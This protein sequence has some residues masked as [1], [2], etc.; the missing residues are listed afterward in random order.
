MRP[1][2]ADPHESTAVVRVALGRAITQ[3]RCPGKDEV[4]VIGLDTPLELIRCYR[5]CRAGADWSQGWRIVDWRKLEE[6]LSRQ[7]DVGCAASF[8]GEP[9]AATIISFRFLR[10]SLPQLVAPSNLELSD[11]STYPHD[12][13]N[14][15]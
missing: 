8:I 6:A 3:Q 7:G 4:H 13:D 10:R 14:W 2:E 9:R 5:R 1:S 11:N 15:R 12:G